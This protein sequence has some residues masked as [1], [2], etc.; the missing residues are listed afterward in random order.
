SFDTDSQRSIYKV[1]EVRLLPAREFPLDEEAQTRFRRS[2]RDKFEVDPSR[3]KV[4]K[5]ISK[6]VPSA[7]IEYYLPLFFERTAL[8]TDYL[9]RDTLIVA[10]EGLQPVVEQFW[11]DTHARYT[12]LRSDRENPPLPPHDLFL[13]T[14]E[15]FGAIKPYARVELAGSDDSRL[16]TDDWQQPVSPQSSAVTPPS[17]VGRQSPVVTPL[18]PLAVERR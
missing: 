14:D 12:M 18:P 15:F 2:F 17:P 3:S 5:D 10:Q 8:I 9:A 4:Y 11:R 13:T 1:N 16:T 6:G 7:G